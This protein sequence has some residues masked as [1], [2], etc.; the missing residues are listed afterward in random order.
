MLAVDWAFAAV[1][2]LSLLVGA[3]RGLVHE[4]LSLM[5]WVAGFLL[6]Q[7]FAPAVGNW[8]PMAGA[9]DMIR[10]AAG[11]LMVFICVMLLTG[12]LSFVLKKALSSVGL[13]PVDRVLGS[14]FGG[15]RGLILVWAATVVVSMTPL[16]T[17]DWWRESQAVAL[18]VGSLQRVKPLLPQEFAKYIP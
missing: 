13:R 1:M 5:S 10:Y 9:S 12:L 6:A 15:M 7:W 18:S 11:F 8:L 4:V 14:L 2:L 17:S 3:V 16:K